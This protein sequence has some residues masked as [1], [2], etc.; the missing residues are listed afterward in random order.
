L[1]LVGELVL[2]VGDDPPHLLARQRPPPLVAEHLVDGVRVPARRRLRVRRDR[3]LRV[4]Q[5]GGA[6]AEG[7]EGGGEQNEGGAEAAHG[8][9]GSTKTAQRRPPR[10]AMG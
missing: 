8:G 2:L 6:A 7:R 9:E 10:V 1:A 3:P 5:A 4:R